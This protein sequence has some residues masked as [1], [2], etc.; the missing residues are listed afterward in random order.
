MP[1][2]GRVAVRRR[3]VHYFDGLGIL[4]FTPS[5]NHASVTSYTIRLY[6]LGTTSPV[7]GERNIGTPSP[8]E[9]NQIRHDINTMLS[10]LANGNYYPS[11]LASFS[12]GSVESTGQSFSLP[13]SG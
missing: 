13:L 1:V 3:Y 4:T 7:V 9:S 8:D 6:A 2:F 10:G 5:T 12:S 11:I